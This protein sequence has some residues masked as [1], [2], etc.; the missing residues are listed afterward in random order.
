MARPDG[1]PLSCFEKLKVLNE[2]IEEV[3]GMCQDV[4]E[5]AVLMGCDEAQVRHVLHRLV[6]G[7]KEPFKS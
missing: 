6:D 5:D 3:R 4:L 2:N 1:T 7:L